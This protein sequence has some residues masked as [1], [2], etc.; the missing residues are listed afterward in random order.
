MTP[1]K[2]TPLYD[3]HREHG[4][5]LAP[6]AG[7]EMPVQYTGIL[8]EHSAVRQ[9]A[10]L[11][12]VSHMGEIEVAGPQAEAFLNYL[13]TNDVAGLPPGRAIY[14][15]MCRDEGGVVDD[16]IICRLE[17]GKFLLCVNA[18]NTAKDAEWAARQA[19]GWDCAVSD[20]SP[21]YAQL[22]LQGPAAE[23]ILT[24]LAPFDL[25]SLKRFSFRACDMAGVPALISR[26]GYTGEDGFEICLPWDCAERPA[27]SVLD[28]GKATGL[29]WCG[30][31]A[32]DSLR[33]EA[34]LPLYG[35]EI[36]ENA[37]PLRAGL[38]WAVKLRTK[39]EFI[40]KKALAAEKERGPEQRLI[41]FRL[42]GRRI[43]RQGTPVLCNGQTAGRVASGAFSPLL[44]RAIGSA[45]VRRETKGELHVELRGRKTNLEVRRPPLHKD[46]R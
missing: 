27:R 17:T 35:H 38:G 20:R 10:G 24:P 42:E 28:A 31:G 19:E 12:D 33:L 6:Y 39:K 9:A 1:L 34:G 26:T 3:L 43:A 44:K 7:W 16:L 2:R 4:A 29:N 22:A 5:R 23:S 32:R 25:S 15:L 13:V 14:A 41:Y 36:D 30:L 45:F 40:G 21:E 37:T 11:F 8:A 18:V 46:T